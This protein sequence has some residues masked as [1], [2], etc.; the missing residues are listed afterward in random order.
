[1]EQDK[2]YDVYIMRDVDTNGDVVWGS[3][4]EGKNPTDAESLVKALEDA[5]E[6]TVAVPSSSFVAVPSF[7]SPDSRSNWSDFTPD[8]S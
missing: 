6:V 4:A 8:L 1:M 3:V 2:K 7:S 5:D